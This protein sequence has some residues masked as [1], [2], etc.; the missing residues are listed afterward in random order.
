MV[1]LDGT[2]DYSVVRVL[3]ESTDNE[4]IDVRVF[5]NPFTEGITLLFENDVPVKHLQLF[6]ATGRLLKTVQP[7]A[8]SFTLNLSDLETG[9][10]YLV[11]FQG[12]TRRTVPLVKYR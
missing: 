2:W 9:A 10:Y 12:D 5:P 4:N 6:D 11:Y 8:T 3:D 7:G 1:D